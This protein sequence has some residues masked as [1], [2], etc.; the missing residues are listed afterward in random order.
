[1]LKLKALPRAACLAFLCTGPCQ[2]GEA[3]QSIALWWGRSAEDNFTGILLNPFSVHFEDVD[4]LY[5]TY[6]RRLA[7]LFDGVE[8]WGE[9]GVGRRYGDVQGTDAHMAL[10]AR[11]TDPPWD[12]WLDTTLSL[13]FV[14][15]AYTGAVT[16][17]E[18]GKSGTG[19]SSPVLNYFSPEIAFTLSDRSELLFRMHHRSGVFGL[20]GGV[21]GGSTF[22]STGL[23]ITF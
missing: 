15:P 20:M 5:A 1:M 3:S 19:K 4:I 9:F 10:A 2:A 13:A 17:S 8:L 12:H 23:R 6:G 18:Q 21:T 14:G 7:G 11:W 16:R 22:L